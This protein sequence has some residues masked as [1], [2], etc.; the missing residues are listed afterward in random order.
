MKKKATK[1]T[2]HPRI[3]GTLSDK[4]YRLIGKI[5]KRAIERA[6]LVEA[7]GSILVNRGHLDL[8]M[9][10]EVCHSRHFKLRLREMLDTKDTFSLM[11]DIYMIAGSINKETLGWDGLGVPRFTKS[12]V[13]H[14]KAG[15]A[16]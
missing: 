11:H 3:W 10:L 12:L 6:K 15:V 4:D 2:S 1:S 8:V 16:N 13:K 14:A 7:G 9:D 5:A